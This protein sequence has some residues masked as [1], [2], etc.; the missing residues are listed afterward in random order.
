[1]GIKGI[2]KL[3]QDHAPNS[4]RIKQLKD[5]NNKKIAFDAS[6]ML[7]QF[8]IAVKSGS[9][10]V[11]YDNKA[12]LTNHISGIFYRILKLLEYG[13]T[14]VFV[15]DGKPP[16][17]KF[18]ELQRRKDRC[19]AAADKLETSDDL[20]EKIRLEK[21]T[22][23]VTKEDV[24]ETKFLL[25][26]MGVPFIDAVSEAEATCAEL[27]K[28]GKV[29]A[30]STEDADALTF[31]TPILLKNLNVGQAHKLPILE[32]SH[33]DMLKELNI[34]NDQFIDLC[35]LC[36]CDYTCTLKRVG[37]KTALKL[38]KQFGSI[39]YILSQKTIEN[40]EEFKFNEARQLFKKPE[41]TTGFTNFELKKPRY[42]DLT[43]YLVDK[44]NFSRDRVVTALSR[45]QHCLSQTK[46]QMSIESFLIKSNN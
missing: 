19:K 32:I 7:Y 40:V 22:V 26:L 46:C 24:E 36:G 3:I 14:P 15:F 23:R 33:K 31:G 20:H 17:M 39:E 34:S 45:L 42:D 41:T 30:V 25:N 44:Q 6:L 29:D 43:S 28:I 37:P 8:L 9:Q 1:M 21:R 18:E 12:N 4:I 16:D 5:Y 27:A 10:D 13:I 11:F 38:I 2:T 35:I